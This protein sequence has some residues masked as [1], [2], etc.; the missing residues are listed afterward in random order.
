ML[1]PPIIGVIV[2]AV[3]LAGAFAGWALRQR[4]PEHHLGDETKKPRLGLHGGG[5]HD[6]S[7]GARAADR[8]RKCVL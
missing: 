4:L 7:A 5:C 3:I 6:F 8:E 2:F 1:N